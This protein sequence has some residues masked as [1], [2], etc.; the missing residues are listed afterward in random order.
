[1]RM[2]QILVLALLAACPAAARAQ[3]L[4]V[5]VRGGATLSRLQFDVGGE[6][7]ST[8]SRVGLTG[9][10]FVRRPVLR[11][12]DLQVEALYTQKGT[13]VE[14]SGVTSS[15]WL[16]YLDVPVLARVAPRRGS[17]FYLV[18]GGS[19]AVRVRARTRTAFGGA[20]EEI[21]IADEVTSTDLGLVVGGGVEFGRLIVDGRYTHGLSDID[22][23]TSDDVSIFN[24]VV[25]ITAGVK[26]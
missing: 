2:R 12:V 1:M 23:D 5:G 10:V 22:H 11:R 15:V 4:E 13:K 19:F 6:A 9:G 16:D 3:G 18:G 25:S 7:P 24:R 20:T 14:E 8:P 17:R 21:D 26:F